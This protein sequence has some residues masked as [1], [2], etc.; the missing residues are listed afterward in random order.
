MR[1]I[2]KLVTQE[3]SIDPEEA[4]ERLDCLILNMQ[5]FR[6]SCKKRK[7]AMVHDDHMR[8][9]ESLSV[10]EESNEMKVNSSESSIGSQRQGKSHKRQRSA[11][12]ERNVK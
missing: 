6:K 7:Q 3:S 9:G 10:E 8:Y 12:I 2:I 11:S 1:S 4:D 5:D